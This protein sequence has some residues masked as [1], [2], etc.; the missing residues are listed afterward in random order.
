MND[1]ISKSP[2]LPVWAIAL[3]S[4]ILFSCD[5]TRGKG[6]LI[7]ETRPEKDFHALDI[8][9]SGRVEV[10]TDSVF[11]VEIT[12]EENI[13]PY[14]ETD[15][16][17]GVLKIDF[18]RLVYD[19]DGLRI[20]VAAPSWD[21]FEVE[22]SADVEVKDPIQG[23]AL[24]TRVSGSGD[25]DIFKAQFEK[26][27]CSVAGSGSITLAGKGSFLEGNISGSGDIQALQFP[28]KTSKINISGSGDA[29]LEVSDSLD[30]I[31]NGSGGVE[32]RG[33]AVTNTQ[34]NGSGRVRKI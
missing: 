18:D 3:S 27:I 7:T 23:A 4:L 29:R 20:V 33:N 21:A 13:L 15:V 24:T 2:F 26:T 34:I 1:L 32:Y 25:I 28:V 30:V 6:D 17:N 11:K 9:T 10:R 12:C 5:A 14:L 22:G 19:V 8:H 16:K 31:I